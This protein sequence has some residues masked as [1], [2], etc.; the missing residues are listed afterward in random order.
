M[1]SHYNKQVIE[2]YKKAGYVF[3]GYSQNSHMIMQQ[4]GALGRTAHVPKKVKVPTKLNDRNLAIR[5][6]KK[7]GLT[8]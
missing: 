7:V 8:L 6:L 1:K 3:A 2:A 5:L 4:P